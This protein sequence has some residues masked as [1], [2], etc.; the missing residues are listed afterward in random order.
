MRR[1][2]TLVWRRNMKSHTRTT[3]TTWTWLTMH[4]HNR[5][6]YAYHLNR[7]YKLVDFWGLERLDG[8][9]KEKYNQFTTTFDI[10]VFDLIMWRHRYWYMHTRAPLTYC[11]LAPESPRWLLL[12]GRKKAALK[13]IGKMT[14]KHKDGLFLETQN[15]CLKEVRFLVQSDETQHGCGARLKLLKPCDLLCHRSK[16]C[17]LE[18]VV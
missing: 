8:G 9:I 11:R 13:V 5:Y 15:L 14:T 12:K 6:L 7:T 17:R 3:L 1:N 18:V 16:R 10:L 2:D 4:W